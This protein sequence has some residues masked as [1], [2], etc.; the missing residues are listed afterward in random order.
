[1]LQVAMMGPVIAPY[2]QNAHQSLFYFQ[3][4]T[5]RRQSFIVSKHDEMSYLKSI[6]ITFIKISNV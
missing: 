6:R 2:L 4:A 3:L 5:P 1:M